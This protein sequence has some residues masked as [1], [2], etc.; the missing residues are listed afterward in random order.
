MRCPKCGFEIK[1]GFIRCR[2]CGILIGE[3]AEKGIV[4]GVKSD[5]QSYFDFNVIK[6]DLFRILWTTIATFIAT[7]VIYFVISRYIGI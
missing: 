7:G 3:T 2:K 5:S 4:E 1:R 6:K